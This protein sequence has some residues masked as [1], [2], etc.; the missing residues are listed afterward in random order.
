MNLLKLKPEVIFA[1]SSRLPLEFLPEKFLGVK[2]GDFCALIKDNYNIQTLLD[3]IIVE[4]SA[5][6]PEL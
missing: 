1:H 6:R 3:N 4:N 5:H 2:T